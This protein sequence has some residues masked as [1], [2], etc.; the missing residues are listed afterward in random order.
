MELAMARREIIVDVDVVSQ[1]KLVPSTI[2]C[3]DWVLKL[4]EK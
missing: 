1:V 4:T 2:I 3:F